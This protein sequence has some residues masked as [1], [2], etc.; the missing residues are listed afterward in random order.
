MLNVV[1][2]Y[3]AFN[4]LSNFNWLSVSFPGLAKAGLVNVGVSISH[5]VSM[6]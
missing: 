3:Y 6:L 2:P 5:Q 1:G 4:W